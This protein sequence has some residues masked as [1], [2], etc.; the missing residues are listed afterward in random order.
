MVLFKKKEALRLLKP[1]SLLFDEQGWQN[2]GFVAWERPLKCSD[3]R[4]DT[5]LWCWW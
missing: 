4:G 1:D 2:P 3:R 5:V